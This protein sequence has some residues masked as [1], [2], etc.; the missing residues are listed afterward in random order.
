MV[1]SLLAIWV[2]PPGTIFFR[3]NI[4]SGP[5]P[6][7]PKKGSFV[8]SGGVH[9]EM[10]LTPSKGAIYH[11]PRQNLNSSVMTRDINLDYSSA[12]GLGK[13]LKINRKSLP[14][15]PENGRSRSKTVSFFRGHGQKIRDESEETD[16][17]GNRQDPDLNRWLKLTTLWNFNSCDP[18]PVIC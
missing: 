12:R 1:T 7:Q 17:N 9:F 15:G 4:P 13:L 14:P 10:L 16:S 5:L 3:K 6:S 11:D 18:L 2:P 8:I